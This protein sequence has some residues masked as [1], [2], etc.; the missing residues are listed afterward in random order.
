MRFSWFG[1]ALPG[2][3]GTVLVATFGGAPFYP[4]DPPAAHTGGFGEP[5]CHRCHFDQPMNAPGGSLKLVGVPEVYRAGARYTLT[6]QLARPA[7]QRG[8]FQVSARFVDGARGGRQA[9]RLG[10]LDDRVEVVRDD[11]SAVQYAH[12]TETGTTLA[13]P[14]TMRWQV[15]WT[16]PETAL[17]RVVFHL[18]ANAANDDA[19][20]FGDFVYVAEGVSSAPGERE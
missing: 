18:S 9:G 8:G 1:L 14:D 16:A 4:K 11:S 6:V 19:S 3:L 20:E 17:A 15:T 5:T 12:H 2:F 7:M 10:R 13:A